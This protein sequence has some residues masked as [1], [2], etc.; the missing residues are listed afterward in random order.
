MLDISVQNEKLYET[1]LSLTKVT[2]DI[3]R[4]RNSTEIVFTTENIWEKQNGNSYLK[5]QINKPLWVSLL[6]KAEDEIKE[7]QEYINFI[8]IL[9]SDKI[10]SDQLDTLVGTCLGSIRL[11]ASYIASQPVHEFLSDQDI[12]PFNLSIFNNIYS[13]I[14]SALYTDKVEYE[15]LTPLCGFSS[16]LPDM[17]LD[18]NISI[19]KLSEEEIIEILKLGINLGTS[20]GDTNFVHGL[21]QYALKI[22][23]NLKK[24]VGDIDSDAR[25]DEIEK[26]GYFHGIY[27]TSIIDALRIYKEGKLYP[28]TTIRRSKNILSLGISFSFETPVKQF[29]NNKFEL[30]KD[31]SDEFKEFWDARN[32]T[33]LP[34]KNFLSVGI[35]RFSQSNERNSIEDR[36][37]DL[38]IAAESIFLSSGGSSQGELKY[39]LS[40]RAAMFIEESSIKQRNVFYFMQKAYDVRSAIVHGS[41]PKLPKKM[42]KS[43]YT[44][45]EF[46]D[47]IEKYLRISIKKVMTQ[48]SRTE[49][50]TIDWI[51]VIF[52]EDN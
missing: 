30:T 13:K 36:I 42:D 8:N 32:Q 41:T 46:C 27:E 37:I 29:M 52:P 12:I 33:K 19:V 18:E 4:N 23:F 31:E 44:L 40:H 17:L 24:I 39:R 7:K 22:K 26:S 15:N 25:F 38:M 9:E 45:E 35:R 50:N 48:M 16:H 1:L 47:D 6:H 49:N 11:E 10:I 21:H 5:R 20:F 3:L 14:E 2:L 43:E 28:I 51:A 34:N